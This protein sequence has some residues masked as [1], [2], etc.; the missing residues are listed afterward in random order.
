M[1][2][3]IHYLSNNKIFLPI[4]IFRMKLIHNM[5][6]WLLPYTILLFNINFSFRKKHCMIYLIQRFQILCPRP[7][8]IGRII[9]QLTF[10]I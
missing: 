4:N 8:N 2:T 6:Q 5:E 7:R 9:Y 1:H 10:F 3:F